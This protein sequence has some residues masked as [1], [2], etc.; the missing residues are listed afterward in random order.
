MWRPTLNLAVNWITPHTWRSVEINTELGCKLNYSLILGEVWRQMPRWKHFTMS[1]M[2]WHFKTGLFH[3]SFMHRLASSI[4]GPLIW[5][6]IHDKAMSIL[7]KAMSILQQLFYIHHFP[8]H[9]LY[10]RGF[11]LSHFSKEKISCC[12]VWDWWPSTH[13]NICQV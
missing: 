6:V 10:Y 1:E 2:S 13:L 9:K 12:N 11:F 5:Y 8:S 4:I 3:N 7:Y